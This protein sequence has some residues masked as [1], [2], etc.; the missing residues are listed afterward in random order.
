MFT[1]VLFV[2]LLL[3]ILFPFISTH[4]TIKRYQAI[5]HLKERI[6]EEH[7]EWQI[8][9][10][11]INEVFTITQMISKD[12][13]IVLEYSVVKG[14]FSWIYDEEIRILWKYD[15]L[16]AFFRNGK[17][18]NTVEAGRRSPYIPPPGPDYEWVYA[19]RS[20]AINTI[21]QSKKVKRQSA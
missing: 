15:M 8:S 17:I 16:G 7:M 10:M 13:S 14:P 19:A 3:F 12:H 6:V 5:I 21:K 20:I 18:E 2:V 4:T 11:K 1:F 9:G